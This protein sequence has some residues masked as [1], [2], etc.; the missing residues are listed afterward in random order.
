MAKSKT[1]SSKF[2]ECSNSDPTT[3]SCTTSFKECVKTK[4]SLEKDEHR[5]MIFNP[6]IEPR[7]V[8]FDGLSLDPTGCGDFLI[9]ISFDPTITTSNEDISV[10]VVPW[11][12]KRPK[13]QPKKSAENKVYYSDVLFNKLESDIGILE[14]RMRKGVESGKKVA[15]PHLR[16]NSIFPDTVLIEIVNYGRL[17]KYRGDLTSMQPIAPGQEYLP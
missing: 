1:R 8:S 7:I 6:D 12:N 5:A 3:F 15:L 17:V 13:F 16:P 11:G 2:E 10:S 9:E 14:I 4:H